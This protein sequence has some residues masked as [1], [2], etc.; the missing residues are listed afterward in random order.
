MFKIAD[1]NKVDETLQDLRNEGYTEDTEDNPYLESGKI[2]T[3]AGNSYNF[4]SRMKYSYSNSAF[5]IRGF[6]ATLA[7]IGTFGLA[8][9]FAKPLVCNLFQRQFTVDVVCPIAE[10]THIKAMDILGISNSAKTDSQDNLEKNSNKSSATAH[11]PVVKA[12]SQ[13]FT[14]STTEKNS[15]NS[16]V[17]TIENEKYSIDTK[18][19]QNELIERLRALVYTKHTKI[20]VKFSYT[21]TEEIASVFKEFFDLNKRFSTFEVFPKVAEIKE[22]E[23]KKTLTFIDG[24]VLSTTRDDHSFTAAE[25]KYSDGTIEVGYFTKSYEID[26]WSFGK[27][28]RTHADG[29]IVH[30]FPLYLP[31]TFSNENEYL[32]QKTTEKDG[33]ISYRVLERSSK[34]MECVAEKTPH[35]FESYEIDMEH[36][37][38][39][40]PI[41]K[42]ENLEQ[43][44]KFIQ[45]LKGRVH[46]P[47]T[48]VNI[49][50]AEKVVNGEKI[51][52]TDN[53]Q[54]NSRFRKLLEKDFDVATGYNRQLCLSPKV[55]EKLMNVPGS[56]YNNTWIY[57]NGVTIEFTKREDNS[58]N[59][60][61]TFP[62]GDI[63]KGEFRS[64][65]ALQFWYGTKTVQGK[66]L[67]VLSEAEIQFKDSDVTIAPV[68]Q[69]DGTKKRLILK[70]LSKPGNFTI[71]CVEDTS[72]TIKNLFME[73]L[74]Q[75]R[76]LRETLYPEKLIL[77]ED[78]KTLIPLLFQT[79][80]R[81]PVPPIFNYSVQETIFILNKSQKLAITPDFTVRGKIEK[82]KEEPF[83][84]YWVREL[85][86]VQYWSENKTYCISGL[87]QLFEMN[88]DFLI[89]QEEVIFRILVKNKSPASTSFEFNTTAFS[90]K[91]KLMYDLLHTQDFAE[92]M[93]DRF[94]TLAPKEQISV[95][96]MANRYQLLS[97]IEMIEGIEN[98]V[99][100]Q[101]VELPAVVEG[102]P[103][104]SRP[105]LILPTMSVAKRKEV[106]LQFL[107]TLRE[108]GRLLTKKEFK[109]LS[110]NCFD[111]GRNL[112]RI[113]GRDYL[114]RT[115]KALGL[116]KVKVPNK[117]AVLDNSSDIEIK[118]FSNGHVGAPHIT[119][120]AKTVIAVNR[121][122]S[123]EEI[124]ELSIL[125]E[126]TGYKD[127]T[128]GKKLG[129]NI[130]IGW[131]GLYI[132]DTEF[133]AFSFIPQ[134]GQLNYLQQYLLSTDDAQT[135]VDELKKRYEKFRTVEESIN[136][137]NKEIQKI[138]KTWNDLLGTQHTF[139]FKS[140][141]LLNAKKAS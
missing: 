70:I 135:F 5:L 23:D 29:R 57:E 43:Q 76:L 80:A 64:Y 53:Y 26:Y 45:Y 130:I 115:I 129:Q 11:S 6:L 30:V 72:Y 16:Y 2:V 124:L 46:T 79:S 81:N 3:Y 38:K 105:M 97:F 58:W 119:V 113:L 85:A 42:V 65:G 127:L 117:F 60:I 84:H 108:Q 99:W 56:A 27:G 52:Y 54:W 10:I 25:R 118:A 9:Y 68:L 8:W 112:G 94:C 121:C 7:I 123:L 116:T 83:F 21:V 126:A 96:K 93:L 49:R 131:D 86:L 48:S 107:Q 71:E 101:A 41:W 73:H 12:S 50:I 4:I 104:Q 82:R 106:T 22:E 122:P 36:Y 13:T 51:R 63:E 17:A 28:T 75:G 47:H 39:E 24:T 78:L 138:A 136:N 102:N 137:A 90:P 37:D 18:E 98:R 140:S 87:K 31:T 141:I 134:Y 109:A 111:K 40:N 34:T 114:E 128:I 139:T 66:T 132:I 61:R 19:K 77:D 62:N 33:V 44:E 95:I 91:A 120:Y 89:N 69:E 125:L 15:F 74:D 20:E 32:T 133:D 14:L 55:K 88:P 1:P 92:E 100:E 67:F 59:G 103:I 35:P 110:L